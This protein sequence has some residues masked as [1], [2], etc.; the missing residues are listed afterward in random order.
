MEEKQQRRESILD[1]AEAV[2][3]ERGIDAA[4]MDDVAR[5]A[6][7]SRALVYVYFGDKRELHLAVCQRALAVLRSLFIDAIAAHERGRD[8]L[9][10]IGRAYCDF[11]YSHPCYY[12]ALSRYQATE[13]ESSG[14]PDDAL[15]TTMRAGEAVHAITVGAISQGMR[16]GS[17]RADIDDPMR[18]ALMMW[19]FT[20]GALQIA[21]HKAF[22]L[23]R[24]GI[25]PEAFLQQAAELAARSLEPSQ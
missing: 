20:H 5:I 10:A 22:M 24:A 6:R 7:V 25:A 23:Q 14:D 11:A 1:A 4:T 16:D 8:Q 21:Q 13:A 9:V 2:F 3:A 15:E 19:G 12:Q 18:M 17:L